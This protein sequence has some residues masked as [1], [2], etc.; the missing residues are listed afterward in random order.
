[1]R[2]T[3][4]SLSVLLAFTA[5]CSSGGGDAEPAGTDPASGASAGATTATTARYVE[6][7]D[8]TVL[9]RVRFMDTTGF[10]QPA[11]AFSVLLPR[12]WSHEGGIEWKGLQ[13]CRGEM[14]GARWQAASPDGAIR[15]TSLPV[16]AWGTASDPMM[17]QAMHQ[18]A[19]QG[20][21]EV[22][23]AMSAEQYVRNVFA[24]REL[25]GATVTDVRT[26]DAAIAELRQQAD[27]QMPK[28]QPYLPPGASVRFGMDAVTVRLSWSDGTEGI[29][30]VSVTNIETV[31][32][33][34]FTGQM[35]RLVNASAPERSYIRFPAARR[36]QA[37]TLLANLKSSHRTNPQWKDAIDG[38]FERMRRQQDAIHHQR[39][40]AIAIQTEANSRAHAQRMADIQRQGAAST[41][42]FE[43]RMADMDASMRSWEVQQAGRDRAHTAFV[44]TIREVE[45]WQGA[46]GKV[47]LSSGYGQAW[48]RGDGS[49][50]LSNSP[51]FDPRSVLQ[52]QNW[53]ELK[54][55][56]P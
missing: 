20:G 26:N 36:Q 43:Q 37:E 38:Y 45:T 13:Q 35:Q 4:L 55:T 56:D 44:Q 33:N 24:P 11:E 50:I 22:G 28:L 47:E 9:E 49:Y 25:D 18:Q 42:R 6:G 30:L 54:R 5:A 17:L 40:Q 27:A 34:A 41:Q 46:D 48:S 3:V 32:P 1:M 23:D 19:Q 52:D 8:Y 53:Q 21:C 12:G 7:K 10:E 31:M 51:S 39:M 15:F 2:I 29:A 16:H 14:V